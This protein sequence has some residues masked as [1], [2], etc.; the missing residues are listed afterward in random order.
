MMDSVSLIIK[1]YDVIAMLVEYYHGYD[2]MGDPYRAKAYK[3]AIRAVSFL[4]EITAET[5][6]EAG[7]GDHIS[8]KIHTLISTG[9]PPADLIELRNEM[10]KREN[11]V[12]IL[13]VGPITAGKWIKLGITSLDSLRK[14]AISLTSMQK[15][16]LKYYDD[17]RTRI[18]R[19]E[20]AQIGVCLRDILACSGHF[21]IAGSYRRGSQDSGD[22]DI[23]ISVPLQEFAKIPKMMHDRAIILSAGDEK[24]MMLTRG[25]S[26]I[27]RQI[28]I[29]NTTPA[30]YAAAL[31]YF[32]GSWPHNEM[33]R[34][35]AKAMGLKL[36]QR[37]LYK[38][39]VMIPAQTEQDIYR[40]LGLPYVEPKDR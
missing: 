32:T 24:I 17:L 4:P 31:L 34:G 37:G 20:V 35:R 8:A 21:D 15:Y 33:M 14:S 13:G 5:A 29:M 23:L 16:G 3:N 12:N 2:L 6:R 28:D 11:L 38:D 10:K 1:D 7:V 27:M 26:G 30:T 40:E 19:D 36:N 18:P 9:E 25:P 39:G 22:I